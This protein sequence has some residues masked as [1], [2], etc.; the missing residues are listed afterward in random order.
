MQGFI[1]GHHRARH[2]SQLSP[3]PFP[4]SPE[5]VGYHVGETVVSKVSTVDDA[6]PPVLKLL[7]EHDLQGSPVGLAFLVDRGRG[8]LDSFSLGEP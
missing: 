8:R 7:K 5:P 3:P 6:K 4:M 1:S 2:A